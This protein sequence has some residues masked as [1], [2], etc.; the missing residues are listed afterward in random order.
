MQRESS[1]VFCWKCR[2]YWTWRLSREH[3]FI[4]VEMI[5][6]SARTKSGE[7]LRHWNIRYNHWG[8]FFRFTFSFFSSFVGQIVHIC[9]KKQKNNI[10]GLY[11]LCL[12]YQNVI[13]LHESCSVYNSM[14]SKLQTNSWPVKI[15]HRDFSDLHRVQGKCGEK[16]YWYASAN[17]DGGK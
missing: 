3:F 7:I 6:Y 5:S 4:R 15:P 9:W 1:D 2:R 17:Q 14:N 13:K 10:Y 12:I 16:S 11:N 8:F